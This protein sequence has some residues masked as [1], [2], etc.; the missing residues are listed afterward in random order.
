MLK[1]AVAIGCLMIATIG[2]DASTA[3]AHP[4]QETHAYGGI[5]PDGYYD[6][7]QQLETAG[8]WEHSTRSYTTLGIYRGTFRTWSGKTSSRGMTRHE[9]VNIADRIAFKGW[10]SPTR[11]VWPVGPYGWA[12]VR[13]S[14]KL[15]K[16]ICDSHDPR[17]IKRRRGC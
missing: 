10:Q 8:N 7:V 3:L 12:V 2:L 9:I 17:V 5:L 13:S 6:L 1:R 16:Y 15:Q 11:F 14:P 4:T